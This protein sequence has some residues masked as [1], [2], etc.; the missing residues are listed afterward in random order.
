MYFEENV[1]LGFKTNEFA[2]NNA[3]IMY[4]YENEGDNQDEVYGETEANYMSYQKDN[5]LAYP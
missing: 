1:Q 3:D 4:A 5:T 2:Q